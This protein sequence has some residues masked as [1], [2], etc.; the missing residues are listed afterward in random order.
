MLSTG[1]K[2]SHRLQ[3]RSFFL[4]QSYRASWY[5]Q[6]F[7]YPTECTTRLKFTLKFLH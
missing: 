4:S 5:Y 7:I 2:T 1:G 3:I 6:V